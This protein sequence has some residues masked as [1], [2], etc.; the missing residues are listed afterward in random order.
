MVQTVSDRHDLAR[1]INSRRERLLGL[2]CSQAG[3]GGPSVAFKEF[4]WIWDGV[5]DGMPWFQVFG[6]HGRMHH[7]LLDHVSRDGRE[8]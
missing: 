7:K 2:E 6:E 1:G 5:L 3:A 8:T 4:V